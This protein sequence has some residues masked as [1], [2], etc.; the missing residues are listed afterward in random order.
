VE[1]H[2]WSAYIAGD[3]RAFALAIHHDE[4]AMTGTFPEGSVCPGV[5]S[6]CPISGFGPRGFEPYASGAGFDLPTLPNEPV[7]VPCFREPP[8]NA[9]LAGVVRGLR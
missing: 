4:L 2:L 1:G 5:V 9:V 7:V 3:G 6:V 8:G